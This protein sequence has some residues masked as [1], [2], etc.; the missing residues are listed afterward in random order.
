MIIKN[1]FILPPYV[2][3]G[4]CWN[5]QRRDSGRIGI[6]EECPKC[7]APSWYNLTFVENQPHT[8]KYM[9]NP[10]FD[11]HDDFADPESRMYDIRDEYTAYRCRKCHT[12]HSRLYS[13]SA[14]A[15]NTF[16]ECPAKWYHRYVIN[17]VVWNMGQQI[18]MNTGTRIHEIEEAFWTWVMG[19]V[20]SV[21]KISKLETMEAKPLSKLITYM[22]TRM[23][24]K[25]EPMVYA[26]W[27]HNL[28]KLDAIEFIKLRDFFDGDAGRAYY[29]WVPVHMEFKRFIPELQ[30][31]IIIDNL[32]VLPP[33]YL[34]ND[35]ASYCVVDY[36]PGKFDR[37]SGRPKYPM[38]IAKY[39]W[40]GNFK[41]Q[42]KFYAY[43]MNHIDF[44]TPLLRPTKVTHFEARMYKT[45]QMI[46]EKA[47][48]N[49]RYIERDLE[50]FWNKTEFNRKIGK[51]CEWC[52]YRTKCLNTY[53]L[54]VKQDDTNAT[55]YVL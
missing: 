44:S 49:F 14:S 45:C 54:R 6:W 32:K 3:C 7:G 47:P 52:D 30:H 28:S 53:E 40:N 4:K 23:M 25:G 12:V 8:P 50:E 10:V 26:D 13:L 18:H 37:D 17:T 19:R 51:H 31:T 38:S 16:K 39:D 36:K 48:T 41:R 29:Y 42:L 15:L 43:S 21:I 2:Y 34:S 33:H 22:K 5:R 11:A 24:R 27:I 1:Y 35:D 55:P 46:R 20:P 9:I